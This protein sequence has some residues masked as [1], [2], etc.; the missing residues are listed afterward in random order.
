MMLNHKGIIHFIDMIAGQDQYI[1]RVHH[2]D[3]IQILVNRV[4]SSGV[5]G[6]FHSLLRRQQLYELTQFGAQKTPAF[7]DVGIQ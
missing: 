7:L 6:I 4:C 2:I 5:P 3:D 1:I